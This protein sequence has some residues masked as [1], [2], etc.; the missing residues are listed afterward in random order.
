MWEF[1]NL[2]CDTLNTRG[3]LCFA[4]FRVVLFCPVVIFVYTGS[5]S[6][7][8]L[9]LNL[10][11]HLVCVLAVYSSISERIYWARVKT[12]PIRLHFGCFDSDV[13]VVL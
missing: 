6:F 3:L 12:F 1:D 10:L 2:I 5:N 8:W 9:T 4:L 13:L 7:S 11:V